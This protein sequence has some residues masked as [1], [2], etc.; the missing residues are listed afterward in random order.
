M[1]YTLIK[2]QISVKNSFGHAYRTVII[3]RC[4]TKPK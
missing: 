4:S 2:P 3:N 1:K